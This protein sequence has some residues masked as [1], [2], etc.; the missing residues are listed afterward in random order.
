MEQLRITVDGKTYEVTVEKTDGDQA[1]A[2]SAAPVRQAA[3]VKAAAAAA[4]PAPAPAP[5]QTAAQPGD[6]LSPLAGVVQSVAVE[7]G[8]SVNEGDPIMTLEAMKMY[9]PVNAEA[10]GT[11]K[12]IHVKAGDAVDEGQAIYTIA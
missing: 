2:P 11:V 8:A 4:T 9:T 5:A 12:A 3:P 1:T 10:S 6:V 7:V